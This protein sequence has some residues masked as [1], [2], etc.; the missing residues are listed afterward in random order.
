MKKKLFL[1]LVAVVLAFSLLVLSG[2]SAVPTENIPDATPDE[3]LSP[4]ERE[5]INR[6][7]EL[8]NEKKYKEAY[9][10]LNS[11]KD[12]HKAEEML[13]N[14]GFI[15]T[16]AYIGETP[17]PVTYSNDY[18]SAE[19]ILTDGAKMVFEVDDNGDVTKLR[20]YSSNGSIMTIYYNENGNITSA[21]Q[22]GSEGNITYS[23]S[24]Q[25]NEH[26]DPVLEILRYSDS[27]ESEYRYRYGYDED[28]N[29]IYRIETYSDNISIIVYTYSDGKIE[30]E[31]EVSTRNNYCLETIYTYDENGNLIIRSSNYQNGGNTYQYQYDDQGRLIRWDYYVSPSGVTTYFEAVYDEYGNIIEEN[32]VYGDIVYH[33]AFDYELIYSETNHSDLNKKII[34][35]IED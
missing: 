3:T 24:I 16:K 17:M 35:M 19:I 4:E 6:A 9:E 8:I 33:I 21:E 5:S 22:I 14:F 30:T 28:G 26:G 1:I 2:C 7:E 29:K 32:F 20:T 13:G 25:Y 15:I 23:S 11:M 12:N 18:H 34:Y 27:N 10:I 31:T